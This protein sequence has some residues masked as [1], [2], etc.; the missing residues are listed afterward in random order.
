MSRLQLLKASKKNEA[1]DEDFGGQMSFLEH[2]DELRTRL[3][4][5]M[6]FVLIA[7]FACWFISGYIYNFLARPVQRA[8]GEA[9][10]QRR[11]TIDGVNGQL[12]SVPLNSLKQNDKVRFVFPEVIRVGPVRVP[13]GASVMARV[14]KDSQ[15]NFGLFT[16]EPLS[17][18][19]DIIPKDVKLPIDL[20]RGYDRMPDIDEKMVVTSATEPFLLFVKV[21][22]YAALALSVPF[23][24]WQIWAFVSPGLYPHERKYV[25][26]FI[27]LSSIFFVA[28][29][30]TAYRFIFPPAAKYLLGL[31]QDFRLLLKAD[32]YFD[33]PILLLLG[34]GG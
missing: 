15:G 27:S 2:L 28:G 33:F 6:A 18:G 14:D 20:A 3:I 32:D 26:P 19:N 10:Q 7:A 31:G 9:Q 4:R 12:S 25:T 30:T 17:A 11:V 5:S 16:D 29:A 34:M 13:A 23:L 24:L 22:L 8:L 21:S 1:G